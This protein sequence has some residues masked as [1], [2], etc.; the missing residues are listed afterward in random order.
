MRLTALEALHAYSVVSSPRISPHP[1]S[2]AITRHIATAGLQPYQRTSITPNNDEAESR[3]R[4]AERKAYVT[5]VLLFFYT[6]T[7]DKREDTSV[8]QHGIIS[9][10]PSFA[11]P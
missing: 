9:I 2:I 11:I 5:Y 6:R 8:I 3:T 10:I 4:G 7:T 1:I